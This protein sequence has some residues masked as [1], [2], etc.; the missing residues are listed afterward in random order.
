MYAN[1]HQLINKTFASALAV[2]KK[3]TVSEW[4][5]ASRRLSSKGS[6]EPG[7]W[8]T[9]R[10][11]PTQ[12]PMD[13]FSVRSP[14]RD[15]VLMWPVQ[16]GKTEVAINVVGYTMEE[17]PGPLMVTLP[18]E[19]SMDKWVNQKLNPMLDETPS[20]AET[21]LSVNTRNAANTK[22]FKDFKGGQLYLEHAGN[23]SR[24]KSNSIRTLIVD[25]LD[26]F[27]ANLHSGDDPVDMLDERTSAFPATS[28]RLYISSPQIKGIS[29]IESLWEK[30][31][32]RRYHVPCPDCGHEQH[33]EWSGLVWSPGGKDV[34]YVC[35][36]CGVLIG[37]HHK[38]DMIAK[39][40]WIPGNPGA[41]IRGY[42][43]NCLYYQ[44][45][46]GPRW[47]ELVAKWL[48]IQNDLPR[49]KTFINSRL[50]ETWEDPNMKAA[51][52]NVIADRAEAYLLRVAPHGVCEITAGVDTQDNRL[53]V[54]IV[55][56][57]ERMAS[58]TLDYIVLWGDPAE[59]AVWDALTELLNKPVQHQHGVWLPISAT[60][61]DAGGHRSNDVYNYVRKKLIK[62]PMAIYGAVPNNAPVLSRPKAIDF[63]WKNQVIK[64]GVFIQHVGT[65]GIK[66]KLYANLSVD[67][68]KLAEDRL[69]HFSDQLPHEF[70]TGMVSEIFDPKANRFI[71]KR[72]ARN[73]PLDCFDKE[74]DVL[75]L[76]GW[77]RFADVTEF[78]KLATVDL[79]TDLIEYQKPAALISRH[80]TG[81]MVQLLGHVID[82]LVT[83]NHRMVTLKAKH[84]TISPGVRKWN[85]NVKPEITLAKDLT[86]HHC[87]KI[88]AKWQGEAFATVAIPE[89]K[90]SVGYTVQ[91]TVQVDANDMAALLGWWISEGSIS[92]HRS[93]TQNNLRRAIFIGQI[94]QKQRDVIRTLLSRLPWKFSEQTNGFRITSMQL[95]DYLLQF[96]KLQHNRIVPDWIKQSSPEIIASFV[97]AMIAGDGWTQQK[98]A[99]HRISRVYAT[100]SPKLADD[101]QELF[102]KLGNA[103]TMR[104][105]K[106]SGWKIAGR[107]GHECRTQYHVYERLASRAHL[108]GGG[109]GK[110]EFIGKSVD[111]DD[112]VYCASVPN[113]TLI[114]RR[115]GKTFIA[116]NCWTYAYAA[117]HHQELRLH[118][119]TKQKW[120]ALREQI[121]ASRTDAA[122]TAEPVI[123]ST[124]TRLLSGWNRK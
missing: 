43:I 4:A 62:R 45:G 8:R 15:V 57:G 12:E 29:R 28:K 61:I 26:E 121:N 13:C 40:R 42:H 103:A 82:I 78:D 86:I 44:F 30:S 9:S 66:H 24:L 67:A 92:E 19:V 55:G 68:D 21:L 91:K 70:F 117:T 106:P 46:L 104:V 53:E 85:F 95:H 48:E 71:K 38:T 123:V 101:M 110:R 3:R 94:K 51:K 64:K 75:T 76:E 119:H 72:G 122:A 16:I 113:G 6:A 97:N 84:E 77:K 32:Q 107:S 31:D 90:S 2:R 96:G 14:V 49:L 50:A 102:I 73:E 59:E 25:E 65:V 36:D 47:D 39:G 37:E 114:V 5:D 87:I 98:E 18:G 17:N 112:I 63:N 11:P 116:G 80:Y 100:T 109:N 10:N 56:W 120:Q 118:L 58:W 111:Y 124:G 60:C 22:T 108:D 35:K 27:A 93:K 88:K 105:V 7:P 81:S 41:K 79:E 34:C 115:S 74:T 54:H 99:H 89:S 1:A 33:L 69:V 52:L 23:P 20:V 83:P